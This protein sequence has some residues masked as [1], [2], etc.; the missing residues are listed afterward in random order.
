LNPAPKTADGKA[1]DADGMTGVI[2]T[3]P[4]VLG[5]LGGRS[6]VESMPVHK[7]SQGFREGGKRGITNIDEE[8]G[9]GGLS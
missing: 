8:S 1:K 9:G 2:G 3:G 4:V 6:T 5:S 7:P